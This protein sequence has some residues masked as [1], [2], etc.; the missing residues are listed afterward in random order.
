MS[1]TLKA[2]SINILDSYVKTAPS[3]QNAIDI[4]A[5]EWASKFPPP[6]DG[7]KTGGIPLFQDSRLAW[8]LERLGGVQGQ[9]VLELG[10][11]EGGHSYML[12]KAGAAVIT[13]VEAN[14]RAYL[15]C[16]VAKEILNLSRSRFLAGD[17]IEYLA[18]SK[19]HFDLIVASGVLY[20]MKDPLKLLELIAKHTDRMYMWTHYYDKAIIDAKPYLRSKFLS[21][22]SVQLGGQTVTLHRHDY[23]TMLVEKTFCGGSEE[24]SKWLT[25]ESLFAALRAY[26]FTD[27][28]YSFEN[29]DHPHGPALSFVATKK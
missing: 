21:E 27:F 4:F 26:G 1:D 3:N 10:P 29:P 23:Q 2:P 25:H 7:L 9:N 28:E 15:K 17:F 24:Y 14:T 22:E 8:A 6:F 13:A 20:H 12:E 18:G 19:Q 5:G 16:L 11:L